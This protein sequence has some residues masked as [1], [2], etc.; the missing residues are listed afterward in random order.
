MP[1]IDSWLAVHTC[2][3]G[4]LSAAW[5]ASNNLAD[6]LGIM[7]IV[8]G[9]VVF[10]T[11]WP[12]R[13]WIVSMLKQIICGPPATEDPEALKIIKKFRASNETKGFEVCWCHA[14]RVENGQIPFPRVAIPPWGPS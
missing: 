7:A 10:L 2:L 1:S 13:R 12:Q 4:L 9:V 14:E 5:I 6:I 8:E 3:P 11:L